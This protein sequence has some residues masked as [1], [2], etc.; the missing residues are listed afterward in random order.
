MPSGWNVYYV[1]FLSA[2]LALAIPA[3]LG[4]ISWVVAKKSPR[5]TVSI[6]S[7]G[8]ALGR[9]INTRFFLSANVALILVTLALV[10]IPCV[11]N[12]SKSASRAGVIQGLISILSISG[13]AALGLLYTAR[14]GDL[15]WLRSFTVPA[16]DPDA[17]GDETP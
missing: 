16:S 4:L 17:G 11:G 3:L 10:M 8:P 13:F 7:A 2:L 15:D 5:R 14:K 6:G 1:V 9:R 12:L